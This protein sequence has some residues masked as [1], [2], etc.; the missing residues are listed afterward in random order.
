[1]SAHPASDSDARTTVKVDDPDD[2]RYWTA[3]LR[4]TPSALRD[5]VEEVGT[6]P[7]AV[8]EYLAE[9]AE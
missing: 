1:M 6:S 7:A 3:R 2:V 9:G 4:C 8:E 5:A